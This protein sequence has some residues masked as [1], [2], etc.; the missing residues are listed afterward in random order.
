MVFDCRNN[1]YMLQKVAKV[2]RTP[3]A[4]AWLPDKVLNCRDN[5]YRLQKVAKVNR[6]P[7]ATACLGN[8]RIL[9]IV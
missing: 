2:N 4:M 6:T 5:L 9:L 8:S 1:L 7:V 3:V